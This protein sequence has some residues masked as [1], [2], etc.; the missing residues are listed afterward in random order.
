MWAT[1][2]IAAGLQQTCGSYGG[3]GFGILMYHRVAPRMIDV[4]PSILTVTPEQFRAQ[5]AGLLARGFQAWPLSSLGAAHRQNRAALANVFA[6][7]FD[8]GYQNNFQFAWPIL[9][10]LEIPAT[11]FVATKYLDSELPFPFYDGPRAGSPQTRDAWQPLSTADC[12]QMLAGG[13]VEL[14]AHT[15]SHRRFV[16]RAREFIADMQACLS[17]LQSRFGI[18][19]PAFAFPYGEMD[20]ELVAIARQLDV[21]CALSTRQRRVLPSDDS[22]QWGRFAVGPKDSAAVLAAKIS[23]WYSKLTAVGRKVAQPVRRLTT[24]A[25]K[26]LTLQHPQVGTDVPLI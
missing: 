3:D 11:V 9:R 25:A 6:V 26:P 14:G 13:L 8:D 19:R 20:A 21:W 17:T 16:G 18:V 10:E 24:F 23:G 2:R 5:L 22:Y 15:H 4:T 1:S 12:Q 7:T